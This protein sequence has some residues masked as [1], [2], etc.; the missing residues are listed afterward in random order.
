[1]GAFSDCGKDLVPYSQGTDLL[2][3]G[4]IY[5]TPAGNLTVHMLTQAG[6]ERTA[7]LPAGMIFPVKVKKIF[8]DTT[9]SA[10]TLWI[11]PD[12]Y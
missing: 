7:L 3:G 9:A 5:V 12:P 2:Q 8:A 1:M 11:M 4:Y 10:G 6:N